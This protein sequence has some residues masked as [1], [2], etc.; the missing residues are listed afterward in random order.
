QCLVHKYINVQAI[1]LLSN[2]GYI[3]E[4]NFFG[5]Y[6]SQ[7]NKGA[8]WA[9]QDFKSSMHFYNPYRKKGLYGR[10]NALDLGVGYYNKAR[11]LWDEGKFDK[12]FF[13]FG[14]ALHIVHDMTI[15]Q[16][17]NIKLLDNHRQYEAFVQRMY[18]HVNY[19]QIEDGTYILSSLDKYIRFNARVALKIHHRFKNIRDDEQRFYKITR[20]SLPLAQKTSAGVMVL[21]YKDIFGETQGT[22]QKSNK[23]LPY[24]KLVPGLRGLIRS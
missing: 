1:K 23:V 15:P 10:K 5:S 9:D 11:L 18:Q 16:H 4:F 13:Y 20:C 3:S 22:R 19:F 24:S 17:A 2:D 12:A 6:I 21:L 14:A 8:V 7:I